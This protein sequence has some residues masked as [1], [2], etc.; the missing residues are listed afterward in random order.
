MHTQDSPGR[1]GSTCFGPFEKPVPLWGCVATVKSTS[2]SFFENGHILQSSSQGR[3]LII[4]TLLNSTGDFF[5]GDSVSIYFKNECLELLN[6][7][8]FVPPMWFGGRSRGI[9]QFLP[10]TWPSSN[11][12]TPNAVWKHLV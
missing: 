5:W 11:F 1:R 10:Y 7:G 2:N 9:L 6:R 4:A 8:C 12:E 3:N